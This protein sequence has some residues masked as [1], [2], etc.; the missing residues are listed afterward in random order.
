MSPIL[1]ALFLVAVLSLCVPS[2]AVA[3]E[4]SG[5]DLR[6]RVAVLERKN[7]EL[8]LRV[9]D[10]EARLKPGTRETAVQSSAGDWRNVA[11]WRRLKRGMKYDEVRELLGEP[12]RISGGSVAVWRFGNS[13]SSGTATFIDDELESWTEP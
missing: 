6:Q 11:N 3:Q 2:A 5:D 8:E 7:A 10:L 13:A 12:E 9:R 4:P 1:R